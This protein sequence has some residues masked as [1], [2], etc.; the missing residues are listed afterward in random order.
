VTIVIFGGVLLLPHPVAVIA[1]APSTVSA[2]TVAPNT[3]RLQSGVSRRA[4]EERVESIEFAMKFP[5]ML[6][7]LSPNVAGLFRGWRSSAPDQRKCGERGG[8]VRLRPATCAEV[9]RGVLPLDGAPAR[10]KNSPTLYNIP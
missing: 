9:R 4:V 8:A 2:M 7:A 3:L 10:R 5:N 6:A 1:A